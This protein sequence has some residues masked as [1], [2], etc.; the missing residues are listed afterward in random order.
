MQVSKRTALRPWVASVA[1][2]IVRAT[3]ALGVYGWYMR[4]QRYLHTVV[5]NVHGADLQL[6]FGGAPI[7]EILPLAVDGGGNMTLSFAVLSYGDAL[8]ITVIADPDAVPDLEH[9]TAALQG[10]LETLSRGKPAMGAQIDQM[11]P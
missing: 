4:R 11:H 10:E 5:T 3:V 9:L 8:T 6:T 7:T 2:V 1:A